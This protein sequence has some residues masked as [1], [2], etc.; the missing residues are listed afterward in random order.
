MSWRESVFP[1]PDFPS[2]WVQLKGGLGNQM[3]QYS[4]GRAL[5]RRHHARLG[6]DLSWFGDMA[7][8]TPRKYSLGLFPLCAGLG[9]SNVA[10]G[11]AAPTRGWRGLRLGR[12]PHQA[13]PFRLYVIDEAEA[14][15]AQVFEALPERVLLR[16]YWQSERYFCSIAATIA[17]EFAFP[18]LPSGHAQ[19]LV[20]A[21]GQAANPVAVH[22]RRGDYVASERSR[23][24]HGECCTPDYYRKALDMLRSRNIQPHLFVF[25]DDPGWVRASFDFC[26]NPGEVVDLAPQAESQ[27]NDM[28]LMSLCRHHVIANSS[29]SWWGAWLARVDGIVC[30]PIRWF[31]NSSDDET[32]RCPPD[33]IRL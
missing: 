2:I 18:P 8:A 9:I 27:H 15:T 32:E 7:G 25:S 1:S 30:A 19:E 20:R 4:A 3:F 23:M 6:L 26:G 17:E 10:I 28:H 31:A 12:R 11:G 24:R 33:W 22:V 16:G 5:A 14:R 13:P 29:F 21:I